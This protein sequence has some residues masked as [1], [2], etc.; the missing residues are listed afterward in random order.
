MIYLDNAATCYTKPFSVYKEMTLSTALLSANAG[1]G[2]HYLSMKAAEKI[3]ETAIEIAEL[4]NISNP[5]AIAFTQN[6]TLALNMAILGAGRD[7]HIVTTSMEHNSVLRPINALGNYTI[8]KAD[9]EGFVNPDKIRSAIRHNTGL[10]VISHISNVCG[11]IQNINAIVAAA[12]EFNIPVLLDAAQSAGIVDIDVQRMNIDMLAFSGHKGLM[13]P[14]GT[15]GLYVRN[16]NM[17]IPIIT[18]GTGSDSEKLAQPLNMPDMLQI[19]IYIIL[20][21]I[22]SHKT[23]PL[24][25]FIQRRIYFNIT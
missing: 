1:R 25:H 2:G 15:G 24:S 16:E 12:N 21:S 22:K 13:G 8:V 20:A 5:S 23:A 4:F 6:A 3:S 17:L 7:K 18:G 14:L 9:K 11:S 19:R 10:I